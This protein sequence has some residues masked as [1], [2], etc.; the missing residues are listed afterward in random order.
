MCALL[1]TA[2]EEQAKKKE[3]WMIT[4]PPH[5]QQ[6]DRLGRTGQREGCSLQN[7]DRWVANWGSETSP[8]AWHLQLSCPLLPTCLPAPL[9]PGVHSPSSAPLLLYLADGLRDPVPAAGLDEA[10]GC[11]QA[12][13]VAHRDIKGL[14]AVAATQGL[15]NSETREI[16]YLR[17]L[18]QTNTTWQMNSKPASCLQRVGW[19]VCTC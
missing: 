13:P 7:C 4:S 18:F 3:G 17:G 5:K 19:W 9:P 11:L 14:R 1:S 8:R 10:H 2:S 15:C 16:K 12:H 6:Y